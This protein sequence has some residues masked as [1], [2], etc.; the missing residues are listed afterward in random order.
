[1]PPDVPPAVVPESPQVR[2]LSVDAPHQLCHPASCATPL[3]LWC[4]T[5]AVLPCGIASATQRGAELGDRIWRHRP[6]PAILSPPLRP[7]M[8]RRCPNT[9]AWLCCGCVGRVSPLPLSARARLS[10]CA[11][12]P[13]APPDVQPRVEAD[14]GALRVP[15]R[16]ERQREVVARSLRQRK[17][18]DG[19]GYCS[20]APAESTPIARA[21]RRRRR[22]RRWRACGA[23]AAA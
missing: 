6:P 22:R 7:P 14:E 8:P 15:P 23:R 17:I 20:A 3:H 1:M 19:P 9:S 18:G 11:L 16:L 4:P 10:V 12:Q 21:P 13:P 5:P 2:G